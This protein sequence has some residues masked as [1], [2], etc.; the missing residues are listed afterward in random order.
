MKTFVDEIT[1]VVETCIVCCTSFGVVK[2]LQDT[3]HRTHQM[4]YCPNGHKQYYGESQAERDLKH[5]QENA[6]WWKDRAEEKAKELEYSN[7]RLAATKGVLT[8]TRKRISKG[9]CPCC[10]RQFVNM[11]RHMAGQHPDY[12]GES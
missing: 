12:Q 2:N 5:A 9:V 6:A 1:F 7:H 8:K 4:F 10:N 3:Y 11:T